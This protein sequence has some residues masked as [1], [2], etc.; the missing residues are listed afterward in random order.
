MFKTY[1]VQI[2]FPVAR[3]RSSEPR[4]HVLTTLRHHRNS[5][6]TPIKSPTP[7]V[8]C[9]FKMSHAC[10]CINSKIIGDDNGGNG[11]K[12]TRENIK[13][14][15]L[16]IGFHYLEILSFLFFL[17]LFCVHSVSH[18]IWAKDCNIC[19]WHIDMEHHE[20][21][22]QVALP[23]A[24]HRVTATLLRCFYCVARDMQS[25]TRFQPNRASERATGA[26][27]VS[28]RERDHIQ[29]PFNAMHFTSIYLLQTL[30]HFVCSTSF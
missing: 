17:Y 22:V 15:A 11:K 4:V 29:S 20:Y 9:I 6:N 8:R 14:A 19:V 28:E 7:S 21:H 27:V 24:V 1:F 13:I 26:G 12:K 5:T 16:K 23:A 30:T 10:K 25:S 2:N 18:L 3:N